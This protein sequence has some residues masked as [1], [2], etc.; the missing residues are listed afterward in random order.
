M[1]GRRRR[2]DMEKVVTI[3]QGDAL[4]RLKELASESVQCCVTSPPYFGLRDYGATGQIGIEDDPNAFVEKLVAVF[5]EVRRVLKDDGVLWLNIG[6][7][8]SRSS[9]KGGSGPGG[10]NSGYLDS[11]TKAQA[12]KTGSS[13]VL[14]VGPTDP[15]LGRAFWPKNNLS[16]F[17]GFSLSL[18]APTVGTYD[19][20]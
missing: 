14:L 20:T 4:S 11:Y 17:P 8:Y 1:S 10:K 16:A 3:I 7:S 2:S 18:S 9:A 15:E 5:R 6:D 13:M 12:S 19:R